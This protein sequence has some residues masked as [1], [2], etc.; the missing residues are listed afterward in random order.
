MPP[1]FPDSR[2][3]EAY[4]EPEANRFSKP[5]TWPPPARN[6]VRDF[7]KRVLGWTDSEMDAQIDPVLDR[8]ASRSSQVSFHFACYISM[9]VN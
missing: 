2:V 9:E 6:R 8:F 5:F 4:M 1:N 3:A 7:C